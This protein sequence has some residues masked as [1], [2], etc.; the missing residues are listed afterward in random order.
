[1]N[2][3]SNQAPNGQVHTPL[4]SGDLLGDWSSLST[5]AQYTMQQLGD[6][7]PTLNTAE[8]EVK[9][10]PQEQGKTYW[11]SDDLRKM[12][13]HLVEVAEWLEQRAAKSPNIRS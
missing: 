9:G 5:D 6:F 4:R 7:G 2:Q 12:S 1:M 10:Y 11:S 13:K 3:E 8:K